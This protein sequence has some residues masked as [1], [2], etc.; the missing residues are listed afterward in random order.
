MCSLREQD[1][2]LSSAKYLRYGVS[3]LL[4]LWL[5]IHLTFF[6]SLDDGGIIVPKGRRWRK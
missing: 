3:E 5:K 4:A 6:F 1:E 2:R